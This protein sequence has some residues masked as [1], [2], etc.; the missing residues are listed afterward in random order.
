MKQDNNLVRSAADL[1]RKYDFQSIVILK[2]NYETQSQNLTKVENELNSFVNAITKDLTNL[3]DQVDGNITTWFLNGIPSLENDPANKWETEADKNNHLGDLYYD[4]STGYAYRFS[5]ADSIYSW[6]QLKDSDIAESLALANSAKDTADSKRRVFITQ[7]TP[8][9]D[10]GDLWIKDE[11]L[12]RCQ[13]SVAAGLFKDNDWI[14]AVKYTDD[15][16]AN[17]VDDDLKVLSG[18]VLEIKNSVDEHSIKI[19]QTTEL[20]NQE[21]EKIGLL[22]QSI[23]EVQQT[24]KEYRI[25]LNT[26]N[27]NV[28][29]LQDNLNTT[30]SNLSKTNEN[31]SNL[32]KKIDGVSASFDDFKDN[33]YIKSIENLQDQIDGAIQFWNGAEIP[34]VNNYPANEW[35]TE[36]DKNNHRA[37]IYT[38]I[39]DVEGELKQGKSYRFDKVNGTWQWIELTDNELSAVQALA[40]KA[41]KSAEQAQTTANEANDRSKENSNS[42]T[43]LQ[44]TD[45]ELKLGL[46]NIDAR[47]QTTETITQGL[48]ITDEAQGN[49]LV[50]KDSAGMN[51]LDLRI[52]GNTKQDSREGINQLMSFEKDERSYFRDITDINSDTYF[53][54]ATPL[55][56]NW[57]KFE[58]DM[59]GFTESGAKYINT[60]INADKIPNL[61]PSTKYTIVCEFRNINITALSEGLFIGKTAAATDLIFDK[62]ITYTS[63]DI[64][65]GL[66]KLLC[67]TYDELPND[68]MAL[69]NFV[70]LRAGDKFSFELRVSVLEG[71]W[72]NKDYT[73]ESYGASPSPEFPSKIQNVK[74][75]TNLMPTN[76]FTLTKNNQR[77]IDLYF[78]E[79]LEPG[80][81]TVLW[82]VKDM[83]G[84][85]SQS[86][87]MGW[88]FHGDDASVGAL[89]NIYNGT[90]T[91]SY[92]RTITQSANRI[93]AYISNDAPETATITITD[94]TV[95]KG[96]KQKRCV[97]Y[98]TWLPL[99]VTGKN[100]YNYKDTTNV[101][102]DVIV[103]DDGW[104]TVTYDNSNGGANRWINYFT[105]NLDLKE[106]T[107][108][109]IFL[110]TKGA[111]SSSKAD[112]I[113]VTTSQLSSNDGQ[114]SREWAVKFND[115]G[116][117]YKVLNNI[118][119]TKENFISNNRTGLR[120]IITALAG[121]RSSITF[122]ISVLE[123]LS[124]TPE[125]FNYQPYKSETVNIDL[126][127]YDQNHVVGSYEL[128]LLD[129]VKDEINIK[130]NKAIL[131]KRIGEY[132]CT[133]DE[134]VN[135]EVNTQSSF[136]RGR[137]AIADS[138]KATSRQP[139]ISNYFKY[140]L[141]GY[142]VGTA[143]TINGYFYLQLPEEYT[144]NEQ[145]RQWLKERYEEG[146]PVKIQYL[147]EEEQN[148]D[149]GEYELGTFKGT[150]YITLLSDLETEMYCR[151]V[152][153]NDIQDVYQSK[154]DMN[155]YYN[156]V[157][158]DTRIQ[159]SADSIK[160]SVEEVKTLVDENG[161]SIAEVKNQV[162]QT[163]TSTNAQLEII[164]E[165]L[166]NGV[167]KLK[168]T[169][170]DI[171]VQGINV[172]TNVSKVASLMGNNV[173][174]IKENSAT[175]KYLAFFGYDEAEKKSKAQM[176]N[177]LVTNYFTAGY[178]RTEK[179]TTDEGE[180]RTGHFYNG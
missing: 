170:V 155:D 152:R 50:L 111:S 45:V 126:N 98:G 73:Y 90:S 54:K 30:N 120:T 21:S 159:L 13:L 163:I 9:Y 29:E 76:E 116:T 99:K 33:E 100:S 62:S 174:A 7:P 122:R 10:V 53:Y 5:L 106:N 115:L 89:P 34:T 172:A 128:C 65:T 12:Y 123:D 57:I 132:I 107:Q 110:E 125:T 80:D 124:I 48:K 101:N 27:K 136:I 135:V 167:T 86:I 149:L 46:D 11:E 158:T 28:T 87:S 96:N 60:F 31:V 139:I 74:G 138:T 82:K 156:R 150:N 66:K 78:D 4:Q 113:A 142:K 179:F 95:V 119:T 15:T 14:K 37:D 63:S 104:I 59:T 114:F 41:Q 118:L 175:G 105:D 55:E 1:E 22:S 108:Y 168:N 44:E 141:T 145:Y 35:T 77:T 154:E 2:R 176:D 43:K 144:T 42:I 148:I 67:T 103:D 18:S 91:T 171:N 64:E 97:P 20:L 162:E 94:L 3:Q 72:T 137:F 56:D 109:N 26:T 23:S 52:D 157:E 121:S 19:T 32:D 36:N 24:A 25:E 6:V 134:S 147:L 61:K 169:L 153:Q 69:R 127:K 40:E 17:R 164:N 92:I 51:V 112:Y 177:L 102:A 84:L 58:C 140:G 173:F 165:T 16:V 81:Y 83:N 75:I 49:E 130:D 39:E 178:H 88:A 160:N 38:V 166:E 70:G 79:P 129:S 85:T 117:E 71:D 131:T 93:Y 47:V 146:N 68:H 8:P 133:G 151:Y 161:Q 143:F 180:K